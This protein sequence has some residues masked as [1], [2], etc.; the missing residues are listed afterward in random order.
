[1]EETALSGEVGDSERVV[2]IEVVMVEKRN[3]WRR[4]CDR[5][6]EERLAEK[7]L[8]EAK[9]ARSKR[10]SLSLLFIAVEKEKGEVDG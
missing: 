4:V 5:R 6:G 10:S 1:M 3:E 8:Q 7:Q 2:V 9:I